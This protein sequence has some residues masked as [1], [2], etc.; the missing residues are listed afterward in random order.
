LNIS[1]VSKIYLPGQEQENQGD[2][3]EKLEKEKEDQIIGKSESWSLNNIYF[4]GMLVDD[5][6][7]E[8]ENHSSTETPPPNQ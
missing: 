7:L 6:L 3:K 5:H 2:T 8:S 4:T 1:V